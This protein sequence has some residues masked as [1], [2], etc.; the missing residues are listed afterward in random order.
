MIYEIVPQLVIVLSL[1]GII[2]IL[3]KK[4]PAVRDSEITVVV[5]FPTKKRKILRFGPFFK[6]IG[7]YLVV[8]LGQIA[9]GMRFLGRRG[10]FVLEKVG[11]KIREKRQ[12]KAQSREAKKKALIPGKIQT[13]E[14]KLTLRKIEKPKLTREFPSPKDRGKNKRARLKVIS[15]TPFKEQLSG[16]ELLTR[17]IGLVKIERFSQAEAM[18]LDVIRKDPHNIRVYKVLG[19]LY[20]KQ[21]NFQDAASSFR[22]ALKRGLSEVEIYKKLGVSYLEQGKTREAVRV[23]RRAL[24]QKLAKEYFYLELGKVYRQ[25]NEIEKAIQVYEN[26]VREYPGNYQYIE[27]LEKQRKLRN[28][29]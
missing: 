1:I 20:L 29:K 3:G 11:A 23:Y 16:E 13:K 17:A 5:K 25:R 27:L 14:I 15:V 21:G 4:L 6:K 18:C 2:I 26:L 28:Q 19:D 24:T 7:H 22:E 10:N 12:K 8:A 9:K